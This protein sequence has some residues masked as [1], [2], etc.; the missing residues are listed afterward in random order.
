MNVKIVL[1]LTHIYIVVVVN[2]FLTFSELEN[3][4][5]FAKQWLNLIL[6]QRTFR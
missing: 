4:M 2:E 6:V 3:R 5:K 1:K